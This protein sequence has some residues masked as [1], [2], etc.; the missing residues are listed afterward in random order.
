MLWNEDLGQGAGIFRKDEVIS[1][2]DVTGTKEEILENQVRG[3][4]TS[5]AQLFV[6]VAEG[7]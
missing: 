2:D 5:I 4:Q 6:R 3:A 7:G 1:N